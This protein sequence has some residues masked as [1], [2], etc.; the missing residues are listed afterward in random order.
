MVERGKERRG[1]G[2]EVEA[3]LEPSS[4]YRLSYWR[5]IQNFRPNVDPECK[6]LAAYVGHFCKATCV[7]HCILEAGVRNNP[8][9]KQ[10]H[11]VLV[12]S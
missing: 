3:W 1:A 9:H 7:T 10:S 5:G 8:Q 4:K 11:R 2:G 6:L 12:L